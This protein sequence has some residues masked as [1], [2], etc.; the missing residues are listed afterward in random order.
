MAILDR[1]SFLAA[2]A[3]ATPLAAR[4]SLWADDSDAE[5]QKIAEEAY[6]W[7]LPL[8]VQERYLQLAHS[9][10]HPVNRFTLST[11]LSTPDDKVAGPNVDTLYGFAWLDLQKEP[12]VLHVPDTHDRYYSIQLIDTYANSFAYVGRR[13]TGTKEGH[14]VVA[15]PGWQ[16]GLPEGL[17]KIEAPTNRVLAL[18]RTL[19]RGEADL[20]GAQA[21]Q[22]QYTLTPLSKFAETPPDPLNTV[23]AF[24]VFPILDLPAGGARFFDDLGAGLASDPPPAREHAPLERFAKA[25]I[26]P[27]H[28]PAES[29]D[30]QLASTLRQAAVAA[31]ARVKAANYGTDVNGWNVSYRI[32]SFIT[33]PLLRAS[34]NRWGP[35]AHVAEEALYFSARADAA[36]QPLS[37]AASYRLHFPAGQLPPV[38][39]FWSLI[40]YG[41]DFFLVRNPINRYSISDR[42][43]GLAHNSDGSLDI[44]IQHKAPVQGGSNWLPAPDGGFQ[45]I[46]RTYQPRPE[47]LDRTWKVPPLERVA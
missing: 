32:S 14:Y 22:L 40:L 28:R 4:L 27:N 11:G 17:K 6:I 23:S 36:K 47:V 19:V 39:A 20:P 35:G 13:A 38:D 10:G 15:G 44:Y 9:A 37:G 30:Q 24:N 12:Q 18:T 7:G 29:P 25:G 45:L 5:I 2:S 21:I 31:D 8:V 3:L 42:T 41:P 34:V 46:L 43:A 33:D 16:G 1:R 26:G